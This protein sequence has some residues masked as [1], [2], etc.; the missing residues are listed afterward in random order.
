MIE[1]VSL[2][3]FRVYP[4][5]DMDQ[6]CD[7]VA[8]R[9][10]FLIALGAEKLLSKDRHFRRI[11]NRGVG[12][13]DGI[14]T[15]LALRRRGYRVPKIRGADL[16]LRIIQ[17]FKD[18]RIYLL[19]AEESVLTAALAKLARQW[20][21][22]IVGARN[23]FYDDEGFARLQQELRDKQP[24][25]VFVALGS[26]KQEFVMEQLFAVHPALYV[27]LGGSLDLYTGKV[28]PVPQWWIR[29]FK[30]EGLYRQVYDLRNMK[31][32]RR[33]IRVLPLVWRVLTNTV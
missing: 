20:G 7:F 9:H 24:E 11:V 32:W 8:D 14:G 31:R 23:G 2:C 30:W 15:V 26:P 5:T 6:I 10:T 1:P 17:R 12:Y 33:Q 28:P 19:G 25:L 4:F 16:W 3:R 22:N 27:G 13:A 18:R 21:P 29:L